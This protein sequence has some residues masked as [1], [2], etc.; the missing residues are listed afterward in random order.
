MTGGDP[1][2]D[3]EGITVNL[4]FITPKTVGTLLRPASSLI[5]KDKVTA[6]IWELEVRNGVFQVVK[7][8]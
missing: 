7:I 8:N 5:L 2:V 1:L 3:L 4:G 6:D